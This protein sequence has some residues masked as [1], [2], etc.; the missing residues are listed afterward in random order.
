MSAAQ[1]R[2]AVALLPVVLMTPGDFIAGRLLLLLIDVASLVGGCLMVD[3]FRALRYVAHDF[4][5]WN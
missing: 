2:A 4:L 5:R 1:A 3:R